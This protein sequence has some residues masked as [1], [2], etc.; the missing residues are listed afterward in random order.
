[1]AFVA[2][3]PR[4]DVTAFD[5]VVFDLDN[6]LCRSE[7]SAETIYY[8]A[9]ERAGVDPVGTPED[10]WAALEGPP[11][12]EDEVGYFAD[13][14]RRVLGE[15]H[16]ADPTV[17]AEHL[18]DIVEHGA[19]S[20]EPGAREALSAAAANGPVGLLTNGPERRQAPKLDTLDLT[21][22]FDSVV[23]AGDM[24]RRKPHADPFDRAIADLGTDPARTL[25]VG[26]SPEYDVA[27]A[28][29]AGWPVAWYRADPDA[30]DPADHDPD[31]V[32]EE[33]ASLAALLE[34]DP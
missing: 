13:G 16:G 3:T 22:T 21:A 17:L 28:R 30:P 14:F 1:M 20:Y 32:L 5:A 6:T 15:G 18:L 7:Q 29:A 8:G 27:G 23:Y 25:Y 9:F 31:H 11:A 34:G 33:L 4:K 24:P 10:L 26:D 2:G 19:V 12:V